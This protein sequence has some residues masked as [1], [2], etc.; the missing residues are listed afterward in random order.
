MPA[1]LR[2]LRGHVRRR[3]LRRN[4]VLRHLPVGLR[5][6]P[7]VWR[8][9]GHVLAT[10]ARSFKGLE[11]E[12]V[13]LFDIGTVPQ[14]PVFRLADSYVACSRARAHLVVLTHEPSTVE[15]L[16]R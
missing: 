12:V 7:G 6:L 2:C 10:T 4:R 16:T 5:P 14:E 1:G 9:G 11:A 15:L 3:D 8:R 13:I